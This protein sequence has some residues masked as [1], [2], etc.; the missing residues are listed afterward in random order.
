MY[1]EIKTKIILHGSINDLLFTPGIYYV[2]REYL[3]NGIWRQCDRIWNEENTVILVNKRTSL[4][5]PDGVELT[6]KEQ[7]EFT[8][9][10]LSA[11]PLAATK[12]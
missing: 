6:E 11:K 3:P 4:Y 8:W 10:K 2:E 5:R 9:I 1:C 12:I 7:S